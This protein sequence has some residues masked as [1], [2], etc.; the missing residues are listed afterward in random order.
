MADF[1]TI[2]QAHCL[3]RVRKTNE[4]ERKNPVFKDYKY[5]CLK[6]DKLLKT[7]SGVLVSTKV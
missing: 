1:D 2:K 5:R 6:C 7:L 4:R 3:H